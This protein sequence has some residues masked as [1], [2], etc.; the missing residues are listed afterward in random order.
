MNDNDFFTKINDAILLDYN[1]FNLW[2][3]AFISNILHK[4]IYKQPVS[5]KQKILVLNIIDKRC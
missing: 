1:N 5:K 2:E 4:V 3:R